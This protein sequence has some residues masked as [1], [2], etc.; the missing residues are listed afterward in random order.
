MALNLKKPKLDS[1]PSPLKDCEYEKIF[2]PF[3]VFE[4]TD[5]APVNRFL[6]RRDETATMP[7]LSNTCVVSMSDISRDMFSHRNSR[8]KRARAHKASVR[9]IHDAAEAWNNEAVD[10]TLGRPMDA[11]AT[12]PLKYISFYHKYLDHNIRPAYH[13]TFTRKISSRSSARLPRNPFYRG[14][15]DTNYEY[16]SEEEW[17][18][19]QEGD[20]DINIEDSESEDDD[21][22]DMEDFLDDENDNVPRKIVVRETQPISSG[23]CWQGEIQSDT[24][25]RMQ[26]FQIDVLDDA[27]HFPIDPHST[28]YWA[29]PAK[30]PAKVEKRDDV[31]TK[32]QPPRMPLSSINT[33]NVLTNSGFVLAPNTKIKEERNDLNPLAKIKEEHNDSKPHASDKAIKATKQIPDHLLPSFKA[34]ISG[35]D[36]TKAGLIEILKKQFPKCSKDAIKD[37]LSAV[38]VR[39]GA[40]EV[41]KK[42]VLIA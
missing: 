9:E 13:G 24:P 25:F 12:I 37:T 33:P 6:R 10:L 11:F 30:S 7:D 32:M 41:E 40:K 29:K 36:L 17:E 22:P 39:E 42:W 3:F 14:I 2:P 27:H 23:L 21:E 18:P 20:E 15:P 31:A 19:P 1:K 4:G 8:T 28:R 38:A 35:S 16:D 26:D 34:A 5:V